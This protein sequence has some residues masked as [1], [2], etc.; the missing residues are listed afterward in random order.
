MSI[1]ALADLHLALSCPDKSME[2]FGSSWGEYI[3]RVEENWKKTVSGS[4][5]VLISGDI[6]WATYILWH[7]LSLR[8]E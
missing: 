4:D 8:L 6:S 7:C 5:T 3:S 2:V 1:Y